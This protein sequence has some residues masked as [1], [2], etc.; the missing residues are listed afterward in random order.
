MVLLEGELGSGK[1]TLVKGILNTLAS[2]SE[3]EV[4]SPTFTLVHEYGGARQDLSCGPLP[5]GRRA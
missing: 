3:D 5:G 1:T 2:V 4:N